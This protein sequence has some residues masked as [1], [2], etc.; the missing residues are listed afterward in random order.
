VPQ[1]DQTKVNDPEVMLCEDM[2]LFYADPLGFVMYAYDWNNDASIQV[3][4]LVEPWA[5]KYNSKWGPDKWACEYL[6]DLGQEVL[7]RGFDGI[8]AVTP[9]R[10][11]VTS[12]HGIGKSAMTGWI[13]DWIMSTRPYA[14]GT[15]TANTFT[16]LETK[17][18]AQI[19][20]WTKKCITSHW[21]E[22]TNSKMY[23]K[24]H[25][26]SWF[27]SA[28]TCREEN[29][30]AFAG[31]HAVNST[32]FYINDE[33]SAIADI[34]FQV[35][36]GGLTDG[37][38][39]Q[40]NFGNPTRNTGMFRECW[41]RFR[42]RWKTYKVDSRSVQITNKE[43]LQDMIDDYGIESDTV[44]VRILGEFPSQS[45]KQF[46]SEKD[47]EAAEKRHLK[48]TQ[49][50]FAP[51]VLGVD[52]AWTGDDEF[53]IWLRQGL[54]SEKLG[55]WERNDNDIEMANIL[56]RLEDDHKADA[57]HVDGGFGTGIVSA[58][59]TMGRNWQ[60]I[61][62]SSKSP[63]VGCLNLRAHMWNQMRIWLKEGACIPQ[64]DVLHMDLTGPETVPRIDGKIQLESKED[65]KRRLIPSPNRADALALT[66]AM[67][68]VKIDHGPLK[69]RRTQ[70]DFDPY[71][72]E[73]A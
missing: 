34:I 13:T 28:Q 59:K 69:H 72:M 27:C 4:E 40:F 17:T 71:S 38:P 39:M 35:Q 18:W 50:N 42:H 33:G 46:I 61:W 62:F 45:L 6:E 52:P 26:E 10:L 73:N 8:N 23:H 30:E 64:D 32:S 70:H 15:V 55:V 36:E 44:K 24:D 25:P 53:V 57:V 48:I 63:D 68:V 37:E 16:Q 51:V 31:Q 12:G 67:P 43:H 54:Y 3:V 1:L 11:A 41:R 60:I 66:F 9:I 49:Y 58:G 22:T 65:M 7:N 14:Q 56:A 21:F 2:A 29:S 5:S 47:V 19:I 20:K